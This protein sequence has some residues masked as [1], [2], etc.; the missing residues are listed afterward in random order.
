MAYNPYSAI[1]AIYNYKN[2]WDSANK[3]G[4]TTK[5]NK[6]AEN[7][8]VFYN[9]LRNNGY[10]SVADELSSVDVTG[11]KYILDQ[12]S[13][14]NTGV[15]NQAY[16]T[17]M[18]S[19]TN[20]N[21]TLAGYVDS[22]RK[23]VQGKYDDIY[24]YANQD[25]TKTDE[26]KS[27]FNKMMGKYD[28][29]A[30]QGRDNA[31]ASGGASNGGNI[32]SYAAANAM[33]QQASLT[34]QGQQIAHQAGLDA[35]NARVSNVS[36]ILNNLGVYNSSTYDAMNQTVNNDLNIANSYFTNAETTKNNEVVRLAEQA[37]VT[38]YTPT[39]WTIKN[40]AVYSDFL[41]ADGTF[42]KEKENIDIQALINQAKASGDTETANKLAVVRYKKMMGNWGEYGQYANTGDISSF[43]NEKTETADQFDKT[44]AYN[45]KALDTGSADTRYVADKESETKGTV[46]GLDRS[47][48]ERMLKNTTTPSQELIDAYN[49]ISGDATTYTVENPPPITGANV[50][51]GTDV[52]NPLGD[53]GEDEY[54]PYKNWN[55]SGITL[56]NVSIYGG[57]NTDKALE[58]DVDEFGSKAILSAYS[59]IANGKLGK[60]GSVTNYELADF[61]ITH[62]N[63]NDTDKR[64]LKKVFA[65]FGLDN[66]LLDNVEDVGKGQN[67]YGQDFKYGVEYK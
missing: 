42:K 27:T 19:A 61:L 1:N 63:E 17:S 58:E 44:M 5:K 36:N 55:N 7:A 48:I 8:K 35:Y 52:F 22:D 64:Q 6:A 10:G 28:M 60:N 67:L 37:N 24:N 40:D 45:Y 3:S 29:A 33:R 56:Q 50:D 53:D 31:A 41:N 4:N 51:G 15:D 34:A 30:L 62:S 12:Y 25:I 57:F 20:K 14:K 18:Q 26:Y 59:A 9:Q 65:Y 2:E 47:D 66:K 21:N 11:A 49:A 54:A 46:S 16:N 39:E 32:D 43:K 13:A 38:G 23:D